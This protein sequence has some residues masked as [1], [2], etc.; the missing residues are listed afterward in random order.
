MASADPDYTT[1]QAQGGAQDRTAFP[2]STEQRD[3][4]P[5][6]NSFSLLGID[7]PGLGAEAPQGP[8]PDSAARDVIVRRDDFT[9]VGQTKQTPPALLGIEV[10]VLDGEHILHG[11]GVCR[12][13]DG[14]RYE[15]EH[16]DGRHHNQ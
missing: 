5:K 15:G 12:W 14:A 8:A 13:D 7:I 16:R 11:R 10:P 4:I 9:Y 2:D 6:R 1:K 3:S